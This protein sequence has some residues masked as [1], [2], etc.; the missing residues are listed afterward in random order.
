MRDEVRQRVELSTR[1]RW[2]VLWTVLA[3][4]FSVGNSGEAEVFFSRR[5]GI[6]EDGEEIPILGGARLSGRAGPPLQ[7]L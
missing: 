2:W 7:R 5:I 6:S 3:G 1:Y 4:L